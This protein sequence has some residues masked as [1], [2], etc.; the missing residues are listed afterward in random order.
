MSAAPTAPD[1]TEPRVALRPLRAGELSEPRY[2]QGDFDDFGPRPGYDQPPSCRLDSD[3]SL[4]V[5]LDDEVVGSVGWHW[6]QWGPGASCRNPMIGIW[7]RESARGRGAGTRA[8]RLLVDL[9]FRHTAVNRVEAHTDVEN[10]GE[11]RALEKAGFT[12]E[13]T[14]RGAQWRA[15]G[16][17]DGYLYSVLRAEWAERPDRPDRPER[18]DGGEGGQAT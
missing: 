13:G 1:T 10:L 17:H 18:P 11:Q 12:R 15:G 3:G 7:L 8:Q 6:V 9:V 16:W 2:E 4:A 5:L 14:V